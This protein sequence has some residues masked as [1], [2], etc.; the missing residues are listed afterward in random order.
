MRPLLLLSIYIYHITIAYTDQLPDITCD[1]ATKSCTISC[2]H[3]DSC[4]NINIIS[5][6]FLQQKQE[7]NFLNN[8]TSLSIECLNED[9]CHH[10]I[11][12]CNN[13]GV[14]N[15]TIACLS[16]D[17]C[18]NV[19]LLCGS[20]LSTNKLKQCFIYT[21]KSDSAIQY[22]LVNCNY[23]YVTNKNMFCGYK[24]G[25]ESDGCYEDNI[26]LDNGYNTKCE[27]NGLETACDEILFQSNIITTTN[28]YTTNNNENNNDNNKGIFENLTDEIIIY[29]GIGL[30]GICILLFILVCCCKLRIKN[31]KIH[32]HITAEYTIENNLKSGLLKNDTLKNTSLKNKNDKKKKKMKKK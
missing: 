2:Q 24:C 32:R 28:I 8:L 3:N 26:C 25:Y 18:R 5:K 14:S 7:Y 29:I 21:L 1:N 30:G 27:C 4:S 19:T 23:T 15:C 17:A 16:D 10:L 20:R 13:F 6:D 11:I 22:S 9:S 31:G 12:N